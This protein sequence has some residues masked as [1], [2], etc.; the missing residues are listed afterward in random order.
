MILETNRLILRRWNNDEASEMYRYTSDPRIG[1]DC[2][3][4]PHQ[5]I[6]DSAQI[7]QEFSQHPE[8]YAIVLKETGQ[9]AGTITLKLGECTDMTDRDDECELGFWI[10]APFW[11]QG[12]ITEAAHEIIR[13]AFDKLAMR[14]IWVGYY[15]G[16]EA[17]RR[18]QEKLGF[19]YHH[20]SNNVPLPA[21]DE[22]RTEHVSLLRRIDWE[23]Q[24]SNVTSSR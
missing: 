17:S 24:Q 22:Y 7:I 3:W 19:I 2:G 12:F 1:H 14:T 20:T 5:N 9:P 21:L 13:H 4:P 8:V 23:S 15:D 18:V 10:G 6:E 11:R 16:N